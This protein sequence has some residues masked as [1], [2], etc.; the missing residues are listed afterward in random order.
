MKRRD[1]EYKV[2]DSMLLSTKNI[3]L[4]MPGARELLPRWIV[5]KV[6]AVAFQLDLPKILRV[7]DVFHASLL[8][9]YQSDG[10]FSSSAST[11]H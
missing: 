11:P 2:G 8:R 1:V 5:K 3:R 6:N 9:P 4:K 10:D 7:H